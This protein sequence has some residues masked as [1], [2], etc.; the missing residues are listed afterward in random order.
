MK[1]QEIKII[2][3]ERDVQTDEVKCTLQTTYHGKNVVITVDRDKLSVKGLAELTKQ[4]FPILSRKEAMALIDYIAEI[5]DTIPVKNCYSANGWHEILGKFYFLHRQAIRNGKI[6]KIYYTGKLD[7]SSKGNYKDNIDFF[8]NTVSKL[9][10]LETLCAVSLSSALVG[11]F[12]DKDL[13][14]IF[15]IEGVST[16]GKTTSLMLAGSI[17]GNPKVSAYGVIKTWNTTDNKLLQTSCGNK[18][19]PIGLDELSMS[20]A[21]NTKLTYI[22]TS[23][24]DKQRMTNADD[25]I[26]E[27]NTVFISTGE[28][29]FKESNYGGIAVRL[30]EVKNYNF[31]NDKETADFILKTIQNTYG[32]IGFEFAKELSKISKKCLEKNLLK[33]TETVIKNIKDICEE[34]NITFSPLFSRM[35]EKVAVI[36]VSAKIAKAKLGMNFNI[37]AIRKFLICNTTLL[38]AGQEQSVEAIEKFLEEYAKNKTKFPNDNITDTNVW[39]KSVYKNGELAEIVVMYNQF[40]KMMANIGFPDTASLIKALKEK[41]FIKCEQ[42]KNYSRRDVGNIKKTKVVVIDV[43]AVKGGVDDEN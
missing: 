1:N 4:G 33:E 30:F 27:F 38:E 22:L 34:R 28:I 31:T 36:V 23:G 11:L 32:H 8:N 16:S 12:K 29:K 37:K 14:F 18:G 15:H 21:N 7:L 20:D 26:N 24:T 35:A 9:V 3:I 6:K 42:G 25:S 10:G 39:G 41:S 40:V 17:W 19:I 2:L 5:E 43:F 13:R